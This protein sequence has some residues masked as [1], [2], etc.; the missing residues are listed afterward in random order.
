M[1]DVVVDPFVTLGLAP[2][3]TLD[4]VRAARRRLAFELHPDRG[5]DERRMREVNQAFDAA[6]RQLTGRAARAT[7]TTTAEPAPATSAPP[8]PAPD[9]R[10]RGGR[11]VG[12]EHD[13]ASF[14]IE[15]LPVEA[16]EALLVVVSWIG[17]ALVDDPPYLLEAHLAEPSPCWCRFELVPD[18]GA[19]TVSLTVAGLEGEAPTVD[20]VRD[21]VVASLNQLGR[22]ET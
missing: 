7:T 2:S 1:T 4:E 3:A 18:A 13:V 19:T 20:A 5:G 10:R 22:L 12:V 6:V 21:V 14:V 16:F 9:V 8:K 15:A 17:E 11:R